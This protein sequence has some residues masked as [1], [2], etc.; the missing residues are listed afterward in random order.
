MKTKI[1]VLRILEIVNAAGLAAAALYYLGRLIYYRQAL[2]A[3]S[4]AEAWL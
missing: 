1:D 4:S 2:A 3:L